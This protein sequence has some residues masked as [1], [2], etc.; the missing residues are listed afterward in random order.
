MMEIEDDGN[1]EGKEGQ[2]TKKQAEHHKIILVGEKGVGKSSL[3]ARYMFA[4]RQEQVQ[5]VPTEK[6]KRL[7]TEMAYINRRTVE[8]LDGSVKHYLVW[9]M[10]DQKQA[11]LTNIREFY[12]RTNTAC[13]VYDIKNQGTYD[14]AK[15]WINELKPLVNKLILVANRIDL[16]SDLDFDY[17]QVAAR[18]FAN[19]NNVHFHAVSTVNNVGIAD[20]IH[21]MENDVAQER[22]YTEN[23]LKMLHLS[24]E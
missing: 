12:D 6:R 4:K 15:Q 18:K 2:S 19:E 20:L 14:E 9:D 23:D 24:K 1:L 3:M 21:D 17:D 13:I 8:K 7:C 11:F 22:P 5:Q 10:G 16:Q